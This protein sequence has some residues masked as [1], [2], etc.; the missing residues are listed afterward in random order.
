[1][2][3]LANKR[4]VAFIGR[5]DSHRGVAEHGFR[6]GR[7]HHHFTLAINEG[8]CHV[9]EF[10]IGLA[11]LYLYVGYGGMAAR[12]P[13][14]HAVAAVD[15]SIPIETNEGLQHCVRIV[16]IHG[17]AIALPVK[18]E[19][20]GAKLFLDGS[21]IVL[22]PVPCPLQELLPPQVVAAQTFR[23]HISLN[24]IVCR[25][26]GMI[27]SGKKQN[28]GALHLLKATQDVLNLVAESVAD[29]EL[30]G[31]IGRRNGYAEGWAGGVRL[32]MKKSSLLPARVPFLFHRRRI[33]GGGQ[34]ELAHG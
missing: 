20:Q 29:V 9:V 2:N 18:G 6:S 33:I 32:G 27:C 31:D 21:T 26:A 34:I 3:L 12:A 23:S 30:T 28:S 17:K 5:M 8:I 4:F 25:D 14:D 16:G 24:H 15:E 19:T 13:V 10:G 1:M 11:V 7:G 22:F